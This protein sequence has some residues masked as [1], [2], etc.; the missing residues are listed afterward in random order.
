[1]IKAACFI[2]D[3]SIKTR[4]QIINKY[5]NNNRNTNVPDRIPSVLDIFLFNTKRR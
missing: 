4:N 1:V 5:G 2:T 3:G